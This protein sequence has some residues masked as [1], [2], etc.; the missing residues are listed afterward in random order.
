[1]LSI[2]GGM[3]K[4]FKKI[5]SKLF[6]KQEVAPPAPIIQKPTHCPAHKKF[7]KGC[8]SCRTIVGY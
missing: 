3:M 4:F 1:M 7:K 6:S 8:S 2:H 5:W